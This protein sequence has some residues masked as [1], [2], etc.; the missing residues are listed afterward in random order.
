MKGVLIILVVIFLLQI[1]VPAW[2]W[3]IVV[4]FVYGVILSHKG[5][6]GFRAGAIGAGLLWLGWGLYL[7]LT[8]SKIIAGRMAVMFSIK[9]S[10]LM[11]LLTAVF[12]AVVGGLSGWAGYLFKSALFYRKR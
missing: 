6:G 8:G 5:S 9:Y 11:L 10:W 7:L 1:L 12:A 3:I 2:W 4:P